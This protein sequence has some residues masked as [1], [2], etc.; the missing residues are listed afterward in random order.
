MALTGVLSDH[1][2]RLNLT[3]VDAFRG[4]AFLSVCDLECDSRGILQPDS[5]YAL[6]KH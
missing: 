5:L 4:V 2:V 1:Y 6:L 3:Y